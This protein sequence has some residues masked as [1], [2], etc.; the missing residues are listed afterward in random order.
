MPSPSRVATRYLRKADLTPPLGFP[1]GPCHV[2]DR[3]K[4][5]IRN[6]RLR[7]ELISDVE[8]GIKLENPEAAKVYDI[9]IERGVGKW[10]RLLIA[11]HAQYRMDQRGIT[12]PELR[13]ALKD[14]QKDLSDL[15]SRKHPT[16]QRW[17]LAL[18]TGEPINYLDKKID[19]AL[20]F[21]AQGDTVR[22]I[23]TYW[24]GE[25]DPHPVGEGGC[26]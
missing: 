16:A 2:V 1:G 25:P 18:L 23:T 19:L 22:V 3:I 7:E 26:T 14:F 20:I 11:P 6:P 9:E 10:T 15:R 12:V 24:E 17:D 5:E 4:E 21:A 13:I 8:K